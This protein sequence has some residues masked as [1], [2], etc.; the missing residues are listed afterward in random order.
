LIWCRRCSFTWKSG[1]F[2]S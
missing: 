2:C 1:V